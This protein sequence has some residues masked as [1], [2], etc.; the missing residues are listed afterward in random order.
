[1]VPSYFCPMLM[2]DADRTLKYKAAIGLA[3]GDFRRQNGRDPDVLDLGSG[4]GLLGLLAVEAG[5]RRVVS[6]DMNEECVAMTKETVAASKADHWIALHSD[7]LE[8]D[9]SQRFDMIVSEM[10]GT[11]CFGEQGFDAIAEHM[12]RLREDVVGGPYVVPRTATQTVGLYAMPDEEDGTSEGVATDA[13]SAA[14]KRRSTS[15]LRSALRSALGGQVRW[16]GTNSLNLH[17]ACLGLV[18]VQPPQ[19]IYAASYVET[20]EEVFEATFPHVGADRLLLC[21]WTAV[22]WADVRLENTMQGYRSLSLANAVGRECAWGFVVAAPPPS[23]VVTVRMMKNEYDDFLVEAVAGDVWSAHDVKVATDASLASLLPADVGT[24]VEAALDRLRSTGKEQEVVVETGE[25]LPLLHAVERACKARGMPEVWHQDE[26]YVS[27]TMRNPILRT[28]VP[29]DEPAGGGALGLAVL[30]DVLGECVTETACRFND[31]RFEPEK[32]TGQQVIEMMQS[33][34]GNEGT[35]TLPERVPATPLEWLDVE[36]VVDGSEAMA[37]ALSAPLRR[38]GGY[39][40]LTRHGMYGEEYMPGNFMQA[41]PLLVVRRGEGGESVEQRECCREQG[42][43]KTPKTT[44]K[45]SPAADAT[46]TIPLRMASPLPLVG[47]RHES[48]PVR[49]LHTDVRGKV[50]SLCTCGAAVVLA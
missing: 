39:A 22:L 10:L 47:P 2:C 9:E 24:V 43:A 33:L 34:G 48:T 35:R 1:M 45:K 42:A 29:V 38:M 16:I 6:V 13:T 32:Q 36:M 40:S 31:D 4:T 11:L 28:G 49:D 50:A 7:D 12:G 8:A 27:W 41:L 17:P 23:D 20:A 15:W 19:P 26:V 30:P 46:T 21:E 18:E 25:N 14:A 3:I 44:T 5:A 37:V